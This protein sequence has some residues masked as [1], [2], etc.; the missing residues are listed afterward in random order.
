MASAQRKRG[1]GALSRITTL[2]STV[3]DLHLRMALQEVDRE[4]RRL[5]GGAIFLLLAFTAIIF[6]FFTLEAALLVLLENNLNLTLS[7]TLLLLSFANLLFAGIGIKIGG[8]ILKGPILPQ[9]FE[10]VSKTFK[11]VLGS[12]QII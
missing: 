7:K 2:A 11:A 8:E 1:L 3:M 9:T 6:A 4:K 12:D 5:I 10:G